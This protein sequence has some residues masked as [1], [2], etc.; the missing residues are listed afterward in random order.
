MVRI[1]TLKDRLYMA[2]IKKYE[3]YGLF[4]YKLVIQVLLV[5]FTS[6][7]VILLVNRNTTYAYSQY[8]IFNTLF[9]NWDAQGSDTVIT[10]T[11]NIYGIP[12]LT[13]YIRTSVNRYYDINSYTI[14]DYSY[15]YESNG[16]KHPPRLLFEYFDNA[17]AIDQGFLFDYPLS[18]INLGPFS[19]PDNIKDFMS[20]VKKMNLEFALMHRLPEDLNLGTQCNEW[21]ISQKYNYGQHGTI[22]AELK[23]ERTLCD[24]PDCKR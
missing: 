17:K 16:L 22:I 15:F 12:S 14:D 2:P 21:T 11:Y 13:N 5:L 7:Q 20:N 1:Q 19:D 23:T 8:L 9:L 4:P 6:L 18:V 3:K 10:N 24:K